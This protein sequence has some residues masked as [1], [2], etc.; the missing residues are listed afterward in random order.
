[1]TKTEGKHF[2]ITC[3]LDATGKFETAHPYK[4]NPEFI[5]DIRKG[6]IL[7]SETTGRKKYLNIISDTGNKKCIVVTPLYVTSR[8]HN[9]PV[10]FDARF[11]SDR[12]VLYRIL[13]SENGDTVE[14]GVYDVNTDSLHRLKNSI[15]DVIEYQSA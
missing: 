1:M 14:V 6:N 15:T 12:V 10:Y 7:T 3:K 11:I 2:Y 9:S 4:I 5:H 8:G 13:T